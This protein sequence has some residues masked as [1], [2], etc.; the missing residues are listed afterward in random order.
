[1]NP[2]QRRSLLS[3][4]YKIGRKRSDSDSWLFVTVSGRNRVSQI[5]WKFDE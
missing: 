4:V 2:P 3:Q 5:F 1:M